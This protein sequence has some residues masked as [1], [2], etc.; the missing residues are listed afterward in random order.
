MLAPE[1]SV[2]SAKVKP[3]PLPPEALNVR[4]PRGAT[5]GAD[6]VMVRPPPTEMV[7]VAV[8]PSESVAV[9]TKE[10]GTSPVVWAT[11]RK[12]R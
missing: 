8:L 7:A 2:V 10:V 3:T 5:V 11:R 12:R 9:T 1:P 6:G 4:A